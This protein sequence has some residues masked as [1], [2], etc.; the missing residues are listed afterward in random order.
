MQGNLGILI[1]IVGMMI[2]IVAIIVEYFEKRDKMRVIEKAIEHGV[3]LDGLSL[4]DPK[5]KKM[6]YRTGMIL[7]AVGVGLIIM[8]ALASSVG[9]G[10]FPS[11][12]NGRL[13]MM[14]LPMI[15]PGILVALIGIA[16][17]I[18]DKMNYSRYLE[19]DKQ[20][21]KQSPMDFSKPS[22]DK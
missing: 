1:P 22:G 4:S 7:V 13:S 2:P 20:P 5:K 16:L 15:G 11:V 3:K 19:E 9:G 17:L 12:G 10:G 21:P 8:A 6:P 14:G 18:N